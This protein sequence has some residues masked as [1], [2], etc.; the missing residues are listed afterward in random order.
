MA[1]KERAVASRARTPCP[2]LQ[3][4]EAERILEAAN[5]SGHGGLGDFEEPR[6]F[7]EAAGLHDRVESFNLPRVKAVLHRSA[8]VRPDSRYESN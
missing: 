3:K 8:S 7:G 2:A 1:V 5:E 6:S 4:L